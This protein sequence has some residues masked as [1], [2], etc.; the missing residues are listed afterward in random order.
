MKKLLLAVCLTFSL[1]ICLAGCGG[2]KEQPQ[3]SQSTSASQSEQAAVEREPVPVLDTTVMP[4]GDLSFRI[5]ENWR[6]E[7]G[8]GNITYFYPL[9][10]SNRIQLMVDYYEFIPQ[11]RATQ[12]DFDKNF[13]GVLEG[14]GEPLRV[15]TSQ[16]IHR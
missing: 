15:P 1:I 12:A 4:A 14:M 8:T 11:E 16:L 6:Q 3:A 5:N 10:I 9:R 7:F 2:S 13:A